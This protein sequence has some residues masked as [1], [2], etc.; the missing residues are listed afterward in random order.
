ML[1][2]WAKSK[3]KIIHNTIYKNKRNKEYYLPNVRV[4]AQTFVRGTFL[5]YYTRHAAVLFKNEELGLCTQ[6]KII[7]KMCICTELNSTNTSWIAFKA[8]RPVT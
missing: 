7:G 4:R 8:A 6:T 3:K 1:T 2:E 5:Y